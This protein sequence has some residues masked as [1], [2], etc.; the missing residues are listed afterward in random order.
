LVYIVVVIVVV[1]IS[2]CFMTLDNEVQSSCFSSMQSS[3]LDILSRVVFSFL[4]SPTSTQR[5]P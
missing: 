2:F 1:C 4:D 3:H 5:I